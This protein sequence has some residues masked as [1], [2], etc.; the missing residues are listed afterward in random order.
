MAKI[1]ISLIVETV[2]SVRTAKM[3]ITWIQFMT[4]DYDYNPEIIK[5]KSLE[6][7]PR[8][9]RK[10]KSERMGMGKR[11]QEM[12]KIENRQAL[13][14]TFSKRKKGLFKKAEQLSLLTGASVLVVAFSP[15]G[16]PFI[17][18]DEG[19]LQRYLEGQTNI[20]KAVEDE[21]RFVSLDNIDLE[22]CTLD[23]LELLIANLEEEEATILELAD[24]LNATKPASGQQLTLEAAPATV[25]DGVEATQL[26]HDLETFL[27]DTE[28]EE[29]NTSSEISLASED[30]FN[31]LPPLDVS[32]YY[33]DSFLR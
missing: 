32:D 3:I 5:T 13:Q 19:L 6:Q 33:L 27:M 17:F 12:K 4:R 21:D 9:Q 8:E 25:I 10:K 20:P 11:K 2:A 28:E 22:Q 16:R 31:D 15:A 14:V 1:P 7:D 24:E 26:H 18:G 29:G 23:E 30:F